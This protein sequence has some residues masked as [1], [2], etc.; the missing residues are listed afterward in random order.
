MVEE[1]VELKSQLQI[2]SLCQACVFVSSEIG[3]SEAR[4]PELLSFLVAFGAECRRSE[5]PRRKDAILSRCLGKYA[6]EV[7][8]PRCRFVVVG[9]IRVV[10][11][12]S[13][14]VIITACNKRF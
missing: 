5:L 13:I 3:L 8:T 6:S 12:V 11:I 9:N 10:Q 4:L 2:P 1:I 14:S 7:S